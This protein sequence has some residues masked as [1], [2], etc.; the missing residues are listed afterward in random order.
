MATNVKL[1][2]DC[3]VLKGGASD[4]PKTATKANSIGFTT[5]FTTSSGN[6]PSLKAYGGANLIPG[7]SGYAFDGTD[8]YALSTTYT[9]TT[10]TAWGFVLS[11]SNCLGYTDKYILYDSVNGNYLRFVDAATLEYYSGGSKGSTTTIEL[12]NTNNSTVSYTLT[13]DVECLVF[14]I[15]ASANLDI[16]NV[17]GDKVFSGSLAGGVATFNVQ[18]LLHDGSYAKNP[19][20]WLHQFFMWEGDALPQATASALGSAMSNYKD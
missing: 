20:L 5:S 13:S 19:R 3:E 6:E 10:A 11:W 4:V 15:S 16:W 7:M 18:H 1:F 17:D 9:R 12:D 14:Q 2:L 8:G